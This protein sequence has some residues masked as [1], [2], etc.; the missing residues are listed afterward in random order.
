MS[1]AIISAPTLFR[2]RPSS[3]NQSGWLREKRF[4]STT[5]SSGWRVAAARMTSFMLRYDVRSAR[6]VS[7]S[8]RLAP[9]LRSA[10]SDVSTESANGSSQ[11]L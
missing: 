1:V 11:S 8:T 7:Q 10:C 9:A 6:S 5:V 2:W 3:W 4:Q